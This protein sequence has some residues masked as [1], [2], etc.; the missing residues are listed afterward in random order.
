MPEIND[1][2]TSYLSTVLDDISPLLTRQHL[3]S[4]LVLVS[5][6]LDHSLRH[7]DT[8]LALQTLL[9]QPITQILLSRESVSCL[10]AIISQ[11]CAYLV[12][13]VLRLAQLVLVCGPE[14]RAV[15]SENLVYEDDFIGVDVEAEFELGV[16]DDDAS[17]CGIISSLLK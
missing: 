3:K 6:L 9:G 13:A 11:T 17:L 16:C 15:G 1:S 14:A 8:I 5:S 10:H 7:L 2:K 12:K 4:L